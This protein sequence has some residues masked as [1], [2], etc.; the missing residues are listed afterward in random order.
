MTHRPRRRDASDA[1]D[2]H[3]CPPIFTLCIKSI[4]TYLLSEFY[5]DHE[6]DYGS[7]PDESD[8]I[9][10]DEMQVGREIDDDGADDGECSW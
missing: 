8:E 10:D 6:H 2:R 7:E 5:D 9:V 1:T 3:R 4:R